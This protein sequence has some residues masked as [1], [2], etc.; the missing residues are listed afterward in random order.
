MLIQKGYMFY[1]GHSEIG[2]T[3]QPV[4][5]SVGAGGWGRE[6]SLGEVQRIFRAGILC[7]ILE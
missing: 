2:K 4:R 6:G 1:I 7:A 3:R 5:V